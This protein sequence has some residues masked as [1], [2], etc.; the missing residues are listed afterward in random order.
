M[1]KTHEH[2]LLLDTIFITKHILHSRKEHFLRTTKA[3]FNQWLHHWNYN[4]NCVLWS[5]ETTIKNFLSMT[6]ISRGVKALK[7][8]VHLSTQT[9]LGLFCNFTHISPPSTHHS[10]KKKKS[11]I[12]WWS[13]YL[14]IKNTL[15]HPT[16][17]L[18]C[19]LIWSKMLTFF[20]T[21]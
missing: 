14:E 18:T 1:K 9:A 12:Q 3:A 10:L 6:A 4:Q 5:D 21:G 16:H 11:N 17:M 15:V 20:L 19:C 7:P 8:T 2:A 13:R